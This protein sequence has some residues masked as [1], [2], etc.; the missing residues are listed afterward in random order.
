MKFVSVAVLA[1]LLT[2]AMETPAI[3]DSVR[4]CAEL[5]DPQSPNFNADRDTWWRFT[6]ERGISCADGDLSPAQ[7]TAATDDDEGD[8]PPASDQRNGAPAKDGVAPRAST[9]P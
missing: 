5:T 1:L 3:A 6:D 9:P 2:P 8:D 4:S 7:D